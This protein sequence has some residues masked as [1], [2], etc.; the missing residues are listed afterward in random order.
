L[1]ITSRASISGVGG[2]GLLTLFQ[3]SY[4][5]SKV[6]QNSSFLPTIQHYLR[7]FFCIGHRTFMPKATKNW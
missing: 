1:N 3:L 2:Q 6:C 5:I 7:V 4:K